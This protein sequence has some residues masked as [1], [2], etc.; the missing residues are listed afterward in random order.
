[1]RVASL[2][3]ALTLG[4][5]VTSP[6]L[7]VVSTLPVTDD[8]WV[9]YSWRWPQVNGTKSSYSTSID[10]ATGS[11]SGSTQYNVGY[12][13]LKFD[14]SLLPE[15]GPLTSALLHIKVKDGTTP[16]SSYVYRAA[17]DAWAEGAVYFDTIPSVTATLATPGDWTWGAD[18]WASV[19]LNLAA[20]DYA[21]DVVDNQLTLRLGYSSSPYAYYASRE[22]GLANAAYVEVNYESQDDPQAQDATA[23]PEPVTLLMS[24]LGMLGLGAC[25]VGR[26][27]RR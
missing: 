23:V 26:R 1:M 19:S 12:S 15:S 27:S 3:T 8:A 6:A 20:W 9:S 10:L 21:A 18:G 24:G 7:A 4:W 2:A 17:S 5:L 13:I 11:F 25:V 16:T 22:S 14:A